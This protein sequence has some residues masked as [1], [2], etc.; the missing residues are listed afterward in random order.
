MSR[1]LQNLQSISGAA[2]AAYRSKAQVEE[3]RPSLGSVQLSSIV[4]DWSHVVSAVFLV[5]IGFWTANIN[6]SVL[7]VTTADVA[8]KN[9]L[10]LEIEDLRAQRELLNLETI[11]K[12]NELAALTTS[13]NSA[14]QQQDQLR[15]QVQSQRE[16]TERLALELREIEDSKRREEKQRIVNGLSLILSSSALAQRTFGKGLSS[17]DLIDWYGRPKA[18]VDLADFSPGSKQEIWNAIVVN[19]TRWQSKD[20]GPYN[21]FAQELAEDFLNQCYPDKAAAA[22]ALES[23]LPQLENFEM[24]F[25]FFPPAG[26]QVTIE[27]YEALQAQEKEA[28]QISER[29]I[30]A[31]NTFVE[32]FNSARGNFIMTVLDEMFLCEQ[33]P[34]A[35]SWASGERENRL[36]WARQGTRLGD[37]T[38]GDTPEY[39]FRD[40]DE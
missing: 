8:E 10:L 24:A 35:Q 14:S 38:F 16:A 5:L 20:R 17:T 21:D 7:E 32:R 13:L 2:K 22:F 34:I 6:R 23:E 27:E 26:T 37:L 12:Q 18:E 25:E 36:T 39:H 4:R 19:V 9:A 3:D 40:T 15:S 33:S 31:A 30:E 29:Q 28:E 1:K 11:D